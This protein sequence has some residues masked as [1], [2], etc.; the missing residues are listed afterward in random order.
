VALRRRR[1]PKLSELHLGYESVDPYPLGTGRSGA[2]GD[3]AYDHF[4][5]EKMA[6]AKVRD[7]E[8]KK[9]VADK[10]TVVYNSGSR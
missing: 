7:P 9:L 5:V 4:R 3:A 2:D 1:P 8:T 6:F 10:S